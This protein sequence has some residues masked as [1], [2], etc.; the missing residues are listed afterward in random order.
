[1]L[2]LY[3]INKNK[4][5]GLKLYKDYCIESTLS[6]GDKVLSFAYPARLSKDIVEECYIRTKTAEFVVKEIADQG[7]WKSIKA[8]LNVEDLEGKEWEHF[9]TTEQTIEQCINLALAGT[10]W[11]IG[12]CNVTKKRTVRKTNCSTWDIIQEAKK[13]YRVELEFDTI[14]KKINIAEK[15]GNDKGVYFMDSL[16]LRSL[17]IQSNSYDFYTR[18]IAKGKDKLKVTVENYQYSKKKK[19][20]IWQD[21]RYTDINSLTE[22][23][24]AKLEELSKPYKAY[25]ADVIDLANMSNKYSILSYRLGDTITLIS[26]EKGIRENQRIVKIVEYPEEPELNTCEIANTLLKFEDIQKEFQDTADTVNNITEDNGTIREDSIRT[27]VEHITINKAD[28]QSLNA[29][30]ARIGTLEVTSATITQLN[31]QSAKIDDLYATRATIKDLEAN[32]GKITVLESRAAS[33]ENILSGN[34]GAENIQ[35]GAI[36]AGSSIIA[37]GAIGS[38]QISS[39]SASK[40]SAGIIDAAVI[41]VKNLNADNITVGSING[42]R[43]APGAIDNSKV[44]TTANIDGSKLNINSVVVAINSG[45]TQINGTKIQVGDRTLDVELS[46]QKIAID[47]NSTEISKQATTISAMDTAISLKVDTQI[48]N[49]FKS[50]T[51]SSISTINNNLNKATSDI[52]VLQGQIKLKVEQSNIDTAISNIQVS[53][54]NYVRKLGGTTYDINNI[55]SADR[56]HVTIVDIDSKKWIKYTGYSVMRLAAIAIEPNTTYTWSFT[57]YTT[58]TGTAISCGEWDGTGYGGKTYQITKT[59]SRISHTFISKGTYEILHISS[60]VDTDN[61]YFADFTLVKGN[62]GLEDWIPAPEDVDGNISTVQIN[63]INSAKDYTNTQISTVNTKIDTA[64]SEINQLKNQITLKVETSTFNSAVTSING[65]ISNTKSRLSTTEQS[66]SILQGQISQKVSQTEIDKSIAQAK[67]IPDTRNVNNPPSWYW[68]T[69]PKQVVTEFKYRNV[70]G[71]PGTQTYGSL[72]STVPWS[73]SS[74]GSITQVFRSL[75]GT[76]ERASISTSAWSAWKQI[77]DTQGAQTKI[78]NYNKNTVVPIA[79]RISTAESSITQMAGQ[80]SSKVDVNGV[81]SAIEQNPASVLIGFNGI[82][83]FV[84]IDPTGLQI[85]NGKIQ[86][87]ADFGAGYKKYATLDKGELYLTSY[88]DGQLISSN[89]LFANDKGLGVYSS[90][91]IAFLN[92][93]TGNSDGFIITMIPQSNVETNYNC[94][95]TL[96]GDLNIKRNVYASVFYTTGGHIMTDNGSHLAVNYSNAMGNYNTGGMTVYNGK[97]DYGRLE[98]G[99]FVA[100]GVKN[101]AVDTEHY[102]TR[103]LNAYETAECYFGDIGRGKIVNG[104]CMVNIEPIFKE[105]VNTDIK[106][107]VKTWAY[108]NGRVWVETTEMYP[109]HFIA[110]GDS[111]IEFGYEIMVKQKDYE[112]ARLQQI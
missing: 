97:K 99:N 89:E 20:I 17:D 62:K 49:N 16:N 93:N 41:T 105:T 92:T 76:Y 26:K 101:R 91:Q 87:N 32:T 74:G 8:V 12:A 98:C 94:A 56:A 107:E 77:E 67:I 104:M 54:R 64:N 61:Y 52:S 68:S 1:M 106:Y 21:E 6:T 69:Y 13:I 112:Y 35:A 34:I 27:A 57:V 86:N 44:S 3:D 2:H 53:G 29:A 73:D 23:A 102:G 88:R 100:H 43:I 59:P 111:D 45:T 28:I 63:A 70:I 66:I 85:N 95:A 11:T 19:T 40:L 47:N 7:E 90:K 4:I 5:K 24:N 79:N 10:G 82:S 38:A 110:R 50:T 83:E 58:G 65:E 14:N 80:I 60:L 109:T 103:G 31:A 25:G 42:Q 72:Q 30:V 108:G 33:I 15:L 55:Y 39:L 84:K 9:D 96:V 71:A 78:D 46:T 37:E 22:D 81:K 18:M 51:D 75:D 48:F 36:Q